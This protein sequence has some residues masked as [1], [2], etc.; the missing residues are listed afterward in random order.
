MM[1][2]VTSIDGA[3]S[4]RCATEPP[5]VRSAVPRSET[6][7]TPDERCDFRSTALPP[8][9]FSAVQRRPRRIDGKASRTARESLGSRKK[10]HL[11]EPPIGA[12]DYSQTAA[13]PEPGPEWHPNMIS[14]ICPRKLPVLTA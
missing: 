4:R 5:D 3:A 2:G 14:S 13:N 8:P 10:F 6:A 7:T 11:E 12:Q 9:H 1:G